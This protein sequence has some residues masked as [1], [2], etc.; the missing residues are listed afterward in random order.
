MFG[1]LILSR[2]KPNTKIVNY[3]MFLKDFLKRELQPYGLK[4]GEHVSSFEQLTIACSRPRTSGDVNSPMIVKPA[5]KDFA[6]RF[7]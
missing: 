3:Q 6:L 7:R 5:D 1:D 4:L 2:S